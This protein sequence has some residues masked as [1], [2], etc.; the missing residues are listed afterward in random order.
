MRKIKARVR[1]G[2]LRFAQNVTG[3][4]LSHF[5]RDRFEEAGLLTWGRHSIG[6]PHIHWREGDTGRVI[7]GSF[8][9]VAE[10]DLFT[11]SIHRVDWITT[12]PVRARMGLPNG[13]LDGPYSNGD[14]RIGNDVWIGNGAMVLSGI[15]IGDGA[16]VGAGAVVTKDVRPYAI[17]VGNPGKEVKRRFTDEQVDALLRIAWWDWD[18]AKVAANADL[19]CSDGVDELIERFG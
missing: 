2:F 19:L 14:I 4:R 11:G 13:H 3:V 12:Y 1:T 7:I 9:G 15:T 10:A 18:D 8:S 17:V 16:V 5:D 6:F